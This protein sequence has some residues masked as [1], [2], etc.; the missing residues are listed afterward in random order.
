MER[1]RDPL[2]IAGLVS[3][4]DFNAKYLYPWMTLEPTTASSVELSDSTGY[5]L[6]GALP[7]LESQIG[8]SD[9]LA[10]CDVVCST[11]VSRLQQQQRLRS[12]HSRLSHLGRL[13]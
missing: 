7:S 10:P 8:Q 12:N 9:A 5:V 1:P 2:A 4:T 13:L 11:A 6:P 3:L